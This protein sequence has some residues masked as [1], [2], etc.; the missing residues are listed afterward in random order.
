MSK[1]VTTTTRAQKVQWPEQQSK[2][3]L[4]NATA[5]NLTAAQKYVGTDIQLTRAFG[6]QPPPYKIVG[7]RLDSLNRLVADLVLVKVEENGS[8]A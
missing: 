8:V 3:W 6:E 1:G 4:R 7:V 5:A 2:I